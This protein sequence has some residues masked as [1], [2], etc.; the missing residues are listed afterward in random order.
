[1]AA[2]VGHNVTANTQAL[3]NGCTMHLHGIATWATS[4]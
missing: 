2:T 3:Y 1:M 4:G